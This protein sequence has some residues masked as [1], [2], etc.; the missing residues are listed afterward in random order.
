MK[1]DLENWAPINGGMKKAV[2]LGLSL[3][4]GLLLVACG[5]KAKLSEGDAGTG[6]YTLVSVNGAQVPTTISH[7]GVGLQV[8]S[9]TFTI[10]ADG[11]CNSRMVF[12]PPSGKE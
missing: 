10:N 11:T 8:R 2:R 7:E 3:V 9:G 4:A 5:G 1:P 12:V 6:V